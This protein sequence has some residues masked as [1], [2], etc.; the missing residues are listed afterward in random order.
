M[1][2]KKTKKNTNVNHG[3]NLKISKSMKNYFFFEEKKLD[4]KMLLEQKKT[5]WGMPR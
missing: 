4:K 1:F 3:K 2:I 5:R